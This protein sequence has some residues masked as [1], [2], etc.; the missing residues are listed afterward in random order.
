MPI[1]ARHPFR[2]WP[3]PLAALILL[4][5]SASV[6]QAHTQ[7]KPIQ[8]WG[9]FLVD[10]VPCLRMMSRATHVCFDAVLDAE[11][12]CREALTRGNECDMA[13]LTNAIDV[14]TGAMRRTLAQECT[15]GQLTELGYIALFDA[16]ADLFNACALQARWAVTATYAP[17]NG[18]VAPPAVA[19]CLTASAAYARRVMRFA[20]DQQT[21][22]IERF[23]TRIYPNP[24]D[25]L[26]VVR[27]LQTEFTAVR[28]RWIDG[29]LAVCP[30]F[31][32]IYG[33]TPESYLRTLT[34]RTDCVLSKTYVNT[35]VSCLAAVCGNGIPEGDEECDDGNHN[36]TDACSNGCLANH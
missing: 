16:E 17:A 31:A 23:A 5:L 25:K 33:R 13:A 36:D 35:A 21:P 19:D 2:H 3:G 29:L 11:Q 12:R 8:N 27:R 10:T 4:W 28:T 18:G 14:A 9:P 26:E 24:E 32:T 22:V 20:I 1:V 6:A 7:P 34:Q 30:D 15:P